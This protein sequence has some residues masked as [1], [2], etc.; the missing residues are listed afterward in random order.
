VRLVTTLAI[1][2]LFV[3]FDRAGRS[4][5]QLLAGFYQC[6]CFGEPAFLFT[7]RRLVQRQRSIILDHLVDVFFGSLTFDGA[8]A[9]VV[10]AFV[11]FLHHLL[12]G[13]FRLAR[14]KS[15]RGERH[16]RQNC[17]RNELGLHA[18]GFHSRAFVRNRAFSRKHILDGPAIPDRRRT[19]VL[20][21]LTPLQK[22][23]RKSQ[24]LAISHY[25]ERQFL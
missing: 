14:G 10:V 4:S 13:V 23:N 18:V 1:G 6:G 12:D 5:F 22:E 25:R 20:N 21:L 9:D 8:L 24:T 7:T 15:E 16:G 3:M 11:N 2:G 17:S 19:N